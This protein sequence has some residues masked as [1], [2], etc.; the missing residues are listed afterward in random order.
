MWCKSKREE[1]VDSELELGCISKL[2]L[3]V[4][5]DLELNHIMQCGKINKATIRLSR[6]T[7]ETNNFKVKNLGRI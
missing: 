7:N 5:I 4:A 6:K 3:E 2:L 1:S